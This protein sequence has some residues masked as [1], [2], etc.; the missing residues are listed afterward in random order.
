MNDVWWLI[1]DD[2]DW[3]L[4]IDDGDNDDCNDDDGEAN[5]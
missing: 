5:N 3:W 1:I 2:G 4:K